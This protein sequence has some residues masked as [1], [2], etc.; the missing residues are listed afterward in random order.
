MNINNIKELKRAPCTILKI[1]SKWQCL[2][3][4]GETGKLSSKAPE[5]SVLSLPPVSNSP[6]E[7]SFSS[8]QWKIGRRG[9]PKWSTSAP[10][11][12]LWTSCLFPF[13]SFP[14]FHRGL[15]N[16]SSECALLNL[17]SVSL[18]H[19]DNV[20]KEVRNQWNPL[21]T[22]RKV[23]GVRCRRYEFLCL[24]NVLFK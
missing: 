22:E 12:S 2:T 11:K 1:E 8:C 10:L 7:E 6:S 19:Y 4:Y 20:R 17:F 3:R 23:T 5:W 21:P 15:G 18:L 9:P 13:L 24:N 16:K 14:S